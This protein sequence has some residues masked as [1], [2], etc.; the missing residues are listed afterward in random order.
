MQAILENYLLPFLKECAYKYSLNKL[1][2]AT[3]KVSEASVHV[4]KLRGKNSTE[5]SVVSG[6]H[7]QIGYP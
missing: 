7:S 3:L 4:V 5:K 2:M 6:M 1:V